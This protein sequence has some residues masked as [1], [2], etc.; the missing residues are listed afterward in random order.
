M[1]L[2]IIIP[3]WNWLSEQNQDG[4]QFIQLSINDNAVHGVLPRDIKALTK[5]TA[6][7]GKIDICT[8]LKNYGIQFIY[9]LMRSKAFKMNWC[10]R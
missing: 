4:Y 1:L 9:H 10:C 8:L 7:N 2:Y 3:N 5:V 6:I